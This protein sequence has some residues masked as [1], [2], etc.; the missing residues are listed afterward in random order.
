LSTEAPHLL[1]AGFFLHMHRVL[2]KDGCLTIV[3]DNLWYGR[4]L[5]KIVAG[6]S[7]PLVGGATWSHPF[8]SA[9]LSEGKS[10]REE[11]EGGVVL[12]RNPGP[13]CGH[14]EGSS[15]FDRLWKREQLVTR[16]FLHLKR[17]TP[18]G[19]LAYTAPPSVPE[20]DQG[21]VKSSKASNKSKKEE[22][23]KRKEKAKK[24]SKSV[25]KS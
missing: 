11:S 6:L 22:K 19:H 9:P 14:T 8:E 21:E 2:A 16:Y 23:K 3:T 7:C 24:N 13:E 17:R 12:Y 4:L 15:Y 20:A 18:D 5:L 25:E 1:T 10:E